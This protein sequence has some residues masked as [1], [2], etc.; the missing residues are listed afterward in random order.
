MFEIF[1]YLGLIVGCGA[2]F[3][4]A[5]KTSI[6][7]R[8]VDFQSL[9]N[10]KVLRGLI[11]TFML[12][13]LF[14]L[15]AIASRPITFVEVITVT[16]FLAGSFFVLLVVNSAFR[17]IQLIRSSRNLLQDRNFEL[18]K[19]N[20]Q[21]DTFLYSTAHDLRAPLTTILGLVDLGK[22]ENSVTEKDYYFSMIKNRV[23]TMDF[24]LKEIIGFTKNKH[25]E[26]HQEPV[27]FQKMIASVLAELEPVKM[28]DVTLEL[29]IDFDNEIW[30]DHQRFRSII[31]N[32]L[33]NS[34]QFFNPERSKAWVKVNA[35]ING[36]ELRVSVVDNGIGIDKRYQEKVFEMFYRASHNSAGSGL[37]LYITREIVATLG[38][39]IHL[40][41]TQGVGTDVAICFPYPLSPF[42]NSLTQTP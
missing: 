3:I 32:L 39:A 19:L 18:Q 1:S 40:N 17:D 9:S 5:L 27:N 28:K 33:S 12:G 31:Y 16:I 4:T 10:W 22:R 41:S 23:D 30:I 42:K 6:L 29:N 34:F 35:S 26:I 25:L 11:I 36:K 21:L 15:G 14:S 37:G 2:L 13:Y 20:I 7:L 8:I 38:G 24:L